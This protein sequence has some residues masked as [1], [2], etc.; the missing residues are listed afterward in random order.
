MDISFEPEFTPQVFPLGSLNG[1]G[2]STLLQL[3][4]VLLSLE[5]NS[6]GNSQLK[7]SYFK[8]FLFN[9]ADSAAKKNEINR[10]ATIMLL[11]NEGKKIELSYFYGDLSE[12]ENYFKNVA[13]T[14]RFFIWFQYIY[15]G[16]QPTGFV[17]GA[18]IAEE[19]NSLSISHLFNK[20]KET[21]NIISKQVV[22]I[23]PS[24][25]SYLFATQE[26]RRLL[27]TSDGEKSY[28]QVIKRLKK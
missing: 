22:L 23:S 2:K 20:F 3:I 21:L 13:N 5:P 17:A 7:N 19:D 24:N 16:I 8:E 28:D 4:F 26:E 12:S 15:G 27:Y 1:G 14:G 9:L 10:L 11:N 25:Q 18:N 6:L